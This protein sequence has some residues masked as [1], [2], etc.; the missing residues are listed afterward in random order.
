MGEF[1]C[2]QGIASVTVPEMDTVLGMVMVLVTVM[3]TVTVTVQETVTATVQLAVQVPDPGSVTVMVQVMDTV[4]VTVTATVQARVMDAVPLAV[5]VTVPATEQVP[6]TVTVTVLATV[7]VKNNCNLG[8]HARPRRGKIMTD[9]ISALIES[10]VLTER[11]TACLILASPFLAI[12]AAWFVGMSA[13][14][15]YGINRE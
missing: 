10:R 13:M 3:G 6:G 14:L 1:Q 4:T 5:W 8:H 12:I 9:A 7:T 15:F 11:Q 2:L